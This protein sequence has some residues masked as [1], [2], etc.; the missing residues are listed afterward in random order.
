MRLWILLSLLLTGCQTLHRTLTIFP[1]Q[2]LMDYPVGNKRYVVVAVIDQNVT[3]P[4]ARKAALQRA[5]KVTR[6]EGYRY[7]T[8]IS[9]EKV[10]VGLSDPNPVP[11][12]TN[13][14]QELIIQRDTN[15]Q[16]RPIQPNEEEGVF[17]ALRL[18]IECSHEKPFLKKSFDAENLVE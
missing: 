11:P 5:A 12:A 8:V 10:F 18:T 16:P 14:Y 15:T 4:E 6:D 2:Q 13:L 9:Q 7:F 3:E 17:P 1:A